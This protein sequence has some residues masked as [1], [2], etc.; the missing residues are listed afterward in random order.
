QYSEMLPWEESIDITQSWQTLRDE[1]RSRMRQDTPW[2]PRIQNYSQQ[3]PNQTI[4]PQSSNIPCIQHYHGNSRRT[5]GT[6]PSQQ[7]IEPPRLTT[8]EEGPTIESVPS[9]PPQQE[10]IG[11]DP[12]SEPLGDVETSETQK[13]TNR[14]QQR[15]TGWKKT[16]GKVPEYNAAE[17]F[18]KQEALVD[19]PGTTNT[20]NGSNMFNRDTPPHMTRPEPTVEYV[21]PFQRDNRPGVGTSSYPHIPNKGKERE[22]GNVKTPIKDFRPRVL[23]EQEDHDEENIEVQKAIIDSFINHER[24]H[25]STPPQ[26][27]KTP[28]RHSPL[29]SSPKTTKWYSFEEHHTTDHV[30][31]PNIHPLDYANSYHPRS[32]GQ[33]SQHSVPSVHSIAGGGGGG[34]PPYPGGDDGY[35]DDEG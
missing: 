32:Q 35:D 27:Y 1:P 7:F 10:P 6:L 30:I 33:R 4:T 17:S 20:R 11:H 18:A 8:I 26:Y 23:E 15:V 25:P 29:N 22:E 14:R 28:S 2:N 31:Q 34:E 24:Q 9:D 5:T 12:S 16:K 19:N 3:V 21:S 13:A